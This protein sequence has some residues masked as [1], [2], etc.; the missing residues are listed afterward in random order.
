VFDIAET[1]E[2][3]GKCRRVGVRRQVIRIQITHHLSPPLEALQEWCCLMADRQ[4]GG[5][6]ELARIM[7]TVVKQRIAFGE[8]VGEGEGSVLTGPRCASVNAFCCTP[9]LRSRRIGVIN[10]NI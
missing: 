2:R 3:S 1:S 8:Q 9:T 7:A 6:A 10:W 4:H 5:T